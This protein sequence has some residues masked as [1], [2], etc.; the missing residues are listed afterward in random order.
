MESL[1]WKCVCL[2]CKKPIHSGNPTLMFSTTK[3]EF[4]GVCHATCSYKIDMKIGRGFHM[5]PPDYLTQQ[6]ISF[7]MQL[8][9]RL[10]SLPGG[11]E[12]NGELREV[13]ADV[14]YHFPDTYLEPMIAFRHHLEQKAR[15]RREEKYSGDLERDFLRIL[16]EIHKAA[17]VNPIEF[18]AD[19]RKKS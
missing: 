12:P 4:L 7:L 13:L 8:Y 19:F 2:T 5:H 3:P 11:L 18:I 16:G 14:T 17:K 10:F 1:T 15:Y 9:P 6:H